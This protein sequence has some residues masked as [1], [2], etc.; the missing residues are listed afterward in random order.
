MSQK[1]HVVLW[2][3]KP[4]LRK[5]NKMGKSEETKDKKG[6]TDQEQKAPE[7][8]EEEKKSFKQRIAD[9][10]AAFAEKHP[11]AAAKL[12]TAKKVGFGIAIGVGAKIGIDAICKALGSSGSGEVI[13]TTYTEV[14]NDNNN[15]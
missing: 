10:K 8:K 12:S 14:D 13:D 6:T 3:N 4:Q 9:N 7:K 1:I 5:E 15:S 2:S 11:K